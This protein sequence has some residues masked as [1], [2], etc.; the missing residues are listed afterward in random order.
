MGGLGLVMEMEMVF[1]FEEGGKGT[2]EL[3][4]DAWRVGQVLL[5][6]T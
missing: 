1:F 6:V 2:D 4:D 3:R 5:V